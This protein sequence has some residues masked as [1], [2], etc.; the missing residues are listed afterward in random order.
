M[1]ILRKELNAIY[2]SQHLSDEILD[3]CEIQRYKHVIESLASVSDA[4]CVITDASADHC[5]IYSGSLARLLGLTSEP[6]YC[7]EQNSS[8]E[9]EIYSRIHPA[10]LVEKRMLEYEFFKFVNPLSASEKKTY[11][12]TSRFRIKFYKGQ[13]IYV[14]N[15]TQV[16]HPSPCGKIWLILCKY[17][18]SP[19]QKPTDDIQAAIICTATGAIKRFSFTQDKCRILTAREK[20]IMTLIMN[21]NLSKQIAA[22]LGISVNTVNRHRQN[23]IS[24]LS[25]NNS[26]EAISAA[27][28]MKL[29]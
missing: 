24:K 26:A 17:A 6:Q 15:S 27:I 8:D 10:D 20:E 14:D 28:S 22:I 11:V 23:I 12:A 2:D 4:L 29:L 19:D 25:V 21:G 3:N 9:D 5:Y 7:T 1:D 13:Y 16:L 18:I